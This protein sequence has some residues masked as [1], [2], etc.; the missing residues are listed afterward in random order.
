MAQAMT[1]PRPTQAITGLTPPQQRE[2][3]IR[4]EWRTVLGISPGLATLAKRLQ[5]SIV[6]LPVGWFILLHLFVL[7]L[8]P[9]VGCAR[10]TLTNRRLM[11]RK[12]WKPATVQEVALADIDD[13]RLDANG[14]DAFYVAGTL[15]VVSKGQVVMTLAGCPEPEGFRQAVL[16]AT[17]AWVPGKEIGHFQPASAVKSEKP[18]K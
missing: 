9:F 11:I 1:Q 5:Q 16:N 12:G 10:Y 17:V 7:K 3:R 6:L 13:V 4:E 2:A 15:Q 8:A 14:V 18:A